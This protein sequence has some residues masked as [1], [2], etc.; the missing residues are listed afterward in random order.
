[1]W[2]CRKGYLLVVQCLLESGAEV[3]KTNFHVS[4]LFLKS[5]ILFMSHP[6]T[7]YAFIDCIIK[8]IELFSYAICRVAGHLSSLL[9]TMVTCR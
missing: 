5:Y 2:A 3:D 7:S 4:V 9:A 8:L 6:A 1:M